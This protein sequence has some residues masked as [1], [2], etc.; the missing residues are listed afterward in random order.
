MVILYC[1]SSFNNT[2][3]VVL[4]RG[5]KVVFKATGGGFGPSSLLKK[6][7]AIAAFR[8]GLSCGIFL[9]KKGVQ[10]V[11]LI[12]SGFGRHRQSCLR[13]LGK[14]GVL[15]QAIFFTKRSAYN[16]CRLKKERRLLFA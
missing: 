10:Q 12:C 9:E 15:V 2:H 8:V 16:G 14:S 6:N 3:L 4:N 5:R 7:S 11:W 1:L 13:G